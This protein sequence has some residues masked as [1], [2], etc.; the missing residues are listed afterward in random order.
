MV[1]GAIMMPKHFKVMT[2]AQDTVRNSTPIATV[3]FAPARRVFCAESVVELP[4]EPSL[5]VLHRWGISRTNHLVRGQSLWIL[6]TVK[7]G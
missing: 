6:A 4:I 3:A 7:A 1:K 5:P 2:P